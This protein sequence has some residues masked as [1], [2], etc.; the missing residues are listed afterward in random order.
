M[1]SADGGAHACYARQWQ[2]G[3]MTPHFHCIILP[4]EV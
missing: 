4:G 1:P 2:A 3:R